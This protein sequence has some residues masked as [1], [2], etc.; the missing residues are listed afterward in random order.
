MAEARRVLFVCVHNAGRSQ[1]AEAILNHE[2]RAQNLPIHAKSA[3]TVG[4]KAVN[5]QAMEALAE[6]GVP[7]DGLVPKFITP[8]LVAEADHIISMGCGVDAEA[9]PTRFMLTEDWGLDDPSGQPLDTV[10]VIRDQIRGHVREF[11]ARIQ[12]GTDSPAS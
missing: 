8:E 10:R 1:M 3:G 6:I 11:L 7:T 4:G 5:P 12:S 2:A 9:C